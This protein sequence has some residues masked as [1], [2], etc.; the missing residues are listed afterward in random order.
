MPRLGRV[1]VPGL[2]H[3]ITQ[4]GN[5]RQNVFFTP[6]DRS[7]YLSLL[8]LQCEHYGLDMH[9]YCLMSNHVH[10]VAV[11]RAKIS[12][13]KAVGVTHGQYASYFN[14]VHGR[15]GHL[16]QSRFYSCTMDDDHYV[17]GMR[18]VEC[19]P[20][21]AGLVA[22]PREYPWSSAAAH[23]GG[24]DPTG[25]LQMNSW[26]WASDPG[27]WQ[28]FLEGK[29]SGE[30]IDRFRTRTTSGYPLGS[31]E[32]VDALEVEL[33]RRLR[34]APRGRPPGTGLQSAR[35]GSE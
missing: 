28:A 3:H 7:Y 26:R 16:W 35:S 5:D 13:A 18:Y 1:V 10:L 32:F 34:S 31:K 9:G 22:H 12:L 17:E 23:C 30:F 15:V 8:G 33:G 21:R 2:P 4:R 11:P 24:C 14:D 27:R 6:E 19:N 25:L 29:T 20:E